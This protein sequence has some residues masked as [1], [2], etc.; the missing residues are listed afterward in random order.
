MQEAKETEGAA[1]KPRRELHT[2]D[3][4]GDEYGESEELEESDRDEYYSDSDADS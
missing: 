4:S 3:N 1:K 2:V